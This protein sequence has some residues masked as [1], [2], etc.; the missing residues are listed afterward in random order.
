MNTAIT[1]P[2]STRCQACTL[3]SR[4]LCGAVRGV[5]EATKTGNGFRTRAIRAETRLQEEDERTKV[6]GIL[7]KGYLRTERILPDGRRGVLGF[8]APGDLVG[9]VL[10]SARGPAL[11][12]ASDAEICGLDPASMRRDRTTWAV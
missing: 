5:S 7:R 9:D 11:V 8:Y 2:L 3:N 12:A 6:T 10:G 4:Q 1:L